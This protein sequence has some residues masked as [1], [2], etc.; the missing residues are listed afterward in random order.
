M[1]IKKKLE[2]IGICSFLIVAASG[3]SVFW[4][5]LHKLY[6]KGIPTILAGNVFGSRVKFFFLKLVNFGTLKLQ[7]CSVI[8][9]KYQNSSSWGI[10]AVSEKGFLNSNIY[11][12]IYK[13]NSCYLY[14]KNSAVYRVLLWEGLTGLQHFPEHFDLFLFLVYRT[15]SNNIFF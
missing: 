3:W 12:T 7:I 4:F 9:S 6:L 5:V 2:S 11:F 8:H 15:L 1:V 14:V 10:W 13:N